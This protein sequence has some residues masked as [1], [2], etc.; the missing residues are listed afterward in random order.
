MDMAQTVIKMVI[1]INNINF[2]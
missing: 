2:I 1:F